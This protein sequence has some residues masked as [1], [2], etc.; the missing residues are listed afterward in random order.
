MQHHPSGHRFPD[1]GRYKNPHFNNHGPGGGGSIMNIEYFEFFGARELDLSR[2]VIEFPCDCDVYEVRAWDG[3]D[4]LVDK[5]LFCEKSFDQIPCDG[6]A[7]LVFH[8]LVYGSSVNKRIGFSGLL[9]KHFGINEIEVVDESFVSVGGE[10]LFLARCRFDLTS[11]A[12]I[13][14]FFIRGGE[15]FVFLGERDILR[16]QDMKMNGKTP[17]SLVFSMVGELVCLGF[18]V[19]LFDFHA[20]TG[21]FS[22][23]RLNRSSEEKMPVAS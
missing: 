3:F 21:E 11:C 12:E 7:L 19:L 13:L 4:L 18:Q 2:G 17:K 16:F 9:K 5:Q 20:C 8:F 10:L 14:R 22:L 6:I 15:G 23:F 1:G